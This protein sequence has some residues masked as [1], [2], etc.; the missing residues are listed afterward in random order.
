VKPN[1]VGDFW[2]GV[3]FT[4]AGSFIL[5]QALGFRPM[6]GMPVGPG[7][8]PSITGGAMALFGLVLALQGWFAKV[9]DDLSL[10]PEE[11]EVAAETAPVRA[12][13]WSRIPF[14]PG[15]LAAIVATILVMPHLG[16]LITGAVLTAFLVVLGGGGWKS[17]VIFS[18]IV[19]VAVYAL[20]FYGLRVPLP[21]GL[22]G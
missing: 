6:P 17:A 2:L 11:G 16:F 21:H 15:L 20:F 18:P 19:T 8:F 9:G 3:V 4:A 7:L 1:N 22:L 13:F 12:D 14:I 10:V 5:I